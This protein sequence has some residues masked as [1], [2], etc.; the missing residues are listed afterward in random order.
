MTH[1]TRTEHGI[2]GN[3]VYRG[4][5]SNAEERAGIQRGFDCTTGNEQY[6]LVPD[7]N[8]GSLATQ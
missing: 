5:G 3:T 7:G 1:Y 6:V 8:I 4:T 2:S